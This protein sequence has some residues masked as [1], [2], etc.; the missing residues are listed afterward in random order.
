M[1]DAASFVAED[2]E[3]EDARS[4]QQLGR[5]LVDRAVRESWGARALGWLAGVRRWDFDLDARGRVEE[6]RV[7]SPERL[8]IIG[9]A[10]SA[11]CTRLP[12]FARGPVRLW[13][14]LG[15][16][17]HGALVERCDAL[18][19]WPWWAGPEADGQLDNFPLQSAMA[20]ARQVRVRASYCLLLGQAASAFGLRAP[21]FEFECLLGR[22]Q[23]RFASAP[24]P[25]SLNPWWNGEDNRA[26][27][28]AF[29]AQ[30]RAENIR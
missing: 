8:L 30:V 2:L 11:D 1:A 20:L 27:A 13:L 21:H 24:H 23:A 4:A 19:C 9:H 16:E 12:A 15:L 5:E 18:N 6:L 28:A 25:R 26:R 10:P 7:G 17:S 14:S 3:L 29:F 22:G